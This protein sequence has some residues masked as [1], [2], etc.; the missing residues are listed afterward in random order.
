MHP[1]L[2]WLGKPVKFVTL[3]SNILFSPEFRISKS[4]WFINHL[5]TISKAYVRIFGRSTRN[6][7]EY[8]KRKPKICPPSASTSAPKHLT[9]TATSPLST[10]KTF[11]SNVPK[12]SC[13]QE[14]AVLECNDQQT[15]A[16]ITETSNNSGSNKT[17]KSQ[18]HMPHTAHFKVMK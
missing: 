7:K 13:Q 1:P 15:A 3:I 16:T 9:Q 14:G 5:E 6:Q 17:K 8:L 18:N 10:Q 2:A 4:T 12:V 11:K